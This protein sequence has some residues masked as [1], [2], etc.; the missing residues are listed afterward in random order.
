[1]VADQLQLQ[2]KANEA[3]LKATVRRL[4][5]QIIVYLEKQNK[6]QGKSRSAKCR[7]RFM[8]WPVRHKLNRP[9]YMIKQN[10]FSVYDFLG[11]LIP[12]SL[13]IYSYLIID[14]LKTTDSFNSS[15]FIEN[16]LT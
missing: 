16:F 9:K 15:D 13:V 12:G 7:T 14:Y 10:P 4:D 3:F 11:Y 6:G 8:Q 2:H 1:M 5:P